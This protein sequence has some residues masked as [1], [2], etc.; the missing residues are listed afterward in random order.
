MTALPETGSNT[1]VDTALISTLVLGG[2]LAVSQIGSQAYRRF[3][4]K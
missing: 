3:A 2:T 1:V 4:I